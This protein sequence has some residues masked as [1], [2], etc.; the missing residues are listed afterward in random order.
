M[1]DRIYNVLFLC[2]GNSVRS[3]LAEGVLRKEGAGWCGPLPGILCL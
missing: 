1:S 3:I 2:I